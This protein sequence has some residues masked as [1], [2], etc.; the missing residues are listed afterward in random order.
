[1]VAG[2]PVRSPLFERFGVIKGTRTLLKQAEI[3]QRIKNI[4]FTVVASGMTGKMF[5]SIPNLNLERIGF[6][7]H[8]LA[9]S[10]HWHRIPI[11]FIR[12]LTVWSQTHRG[13]GTTFVVRGWQGQEMWTFLLPCISDGMGLACNPALVF[14]ETACK[15]LLVEILERSTLWG[16]NQKVAAAVANG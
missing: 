11:G 12:G 13:H 6:E 14:F 8:V 15:E 5:Y 4:L 9:C 7:R 3:V 1:M 10:I 16:R 2:R